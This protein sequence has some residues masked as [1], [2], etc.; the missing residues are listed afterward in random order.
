M[1]YKI[2]GCKVNKYYLNKRLNYFSSNKKTDNNNFIIATCVVTDKAKSKFIKETK[3]QINNQKH[4]Y[5]TWCAVFD[6]WQKMDENKFYK[7][8]PQ[9]A[10]FRNKITLLWEEPDRDDTRETKTHQF[11]ETAN[12]YTKKFIVIQNGCDSHCSFCLTIKK[13]WKSVNIPTDEIIT[14]IN[15]FV[16]IWWKEIVITWI[17]LA[18][19]WATDTK[20]PQENKFAELLKNIIDNTKIERIRISSLW[21]EFLNDKF[22]EIIKNPRFLPH[23]HVSIQSFSDK[24]L[25][26]MNRNYDSKLLDDIITKLKNLDRPDKN[27]ISIWADIIVWFP[28]ET[29]Q[30][31]QNTLDWIRKHQINKLHAFP[32]SS[33]DQWESI[34]AHWFA[35]Q[36]PANIKKERAAKIKILWDKIREEFI[37]KNTWTEQKVLIEEKKNWKRRWRTWNYIQIELEWD[38]TKWEII[39]TIL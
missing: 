3:Q 23:F 6:K 14:E 5:L 32:F 39:N 21:P 29:E 9:L 16:E 37:Q 25:K 7:V 4:I 1:E 17:N 13:R 34:P 24:I 36:I 15:E 22:F 28:G 33:H 26:S 18:A 20:N 19:R 12:I 30:D 8:Y 2:F 11:K 38:Y 31:F 35:D 10:E 27:Q